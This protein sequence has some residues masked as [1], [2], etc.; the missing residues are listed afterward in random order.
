MDHL[1]H[2]DGISPPPLVTNWAS[3]ES[4]R[5]QLFCLKYPCSESI[6]LLCIT[7]YRSLVVWLEDRKIRRYTKEDRGPLSVKSETWDTAFSGYLTELDCP[8]CFSGGSIDC[9]I[10]LIGHAVAVDYEFL[11]LNAGDSSSEMVV[12]DNVELPTCNSEI[13]RVGIDSIGSALK[14]PRTEQENDSGRPILRVN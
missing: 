8:F 14:L 5:R 6:D 11:E 12:I 9:I 13:D 2:D 7:D 1:F 3:M 10:W 4:Y